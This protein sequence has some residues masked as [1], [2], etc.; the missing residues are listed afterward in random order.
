MKSKKIKTIISTLCAAA[1]LST[2]LSLP[3]NAASKFDPNYYAVLYPDVVALLGADPQVLF[4]HYIA[5]GMQEGRQPVLSLL[6]QR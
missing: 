5:F 3:V 2:V 4:N 6:R 1:A